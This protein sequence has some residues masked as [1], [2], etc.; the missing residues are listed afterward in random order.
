[1]EKV[2]FGGLLVDL[3]LQ[4]REACRRGTG[5]KRLLLRFSQDIIGNHHTDFT[6]IDF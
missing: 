6:D 3:D 5:S 4:I 1:M 2:S